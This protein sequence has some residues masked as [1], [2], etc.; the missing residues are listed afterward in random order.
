MSFYSITE[1]MLSHCTGVLDD[2][3][4]V[5][6]TIGDGQFAKYFLIQIKELNLHK[7]ST[8]EIGLLLKL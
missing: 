1:D 5:Y 7:T 8:L 4:R 2:R 3:Y 6:C